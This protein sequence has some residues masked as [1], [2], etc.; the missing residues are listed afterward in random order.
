MVDE[1]VSLACKGI[2]AHLAPSVK[3]FGQEF[4]NSS[5][6]A[7]KKRVLSQFRCKLPQTPYEIIWNRSIIHAIMYNRNDI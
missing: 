7:P 6:T 4:T 5:Q 1:G 2:I 3:G